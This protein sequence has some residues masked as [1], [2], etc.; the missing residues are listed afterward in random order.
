MTTTSWIDL[1]LGREGGSKQAEVGECVASDPGIDRFDDPRKPMRERRSESKDQ[2][3]KKR[4]KSLQ[5]GVVQAKRA[6][7]WAVRRHQDWLMYAI[8]EHLFDTAKFRG[9]YRGTALLFLWEIAE[10]LNVNVAT[11]SRKLRK[12]EQLHFIQFGRSKSDCFPNTFYIESYGVNA[13]S[14][15]N[16]SNGGQK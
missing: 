4:R 6:D 2:R 16:I 3:T 12:L 15:D 5:I 13:D 8:F 9:K 7:R 10:D 14:T 1:A 11:V